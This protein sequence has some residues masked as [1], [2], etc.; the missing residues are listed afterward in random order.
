[1]AGND[2]SAALARTLAALRAERGWSLDQ[3]AA[4]SGVSK[5][6]LVS[7]EQA[8]S[9]PNL[10]TLARVG[11]AF[12]LPVTRLL[13]VPPEPGVR[14]TGRQDARTLVSTHPSIQPNESS[15]T[16]KTSLLRTPPP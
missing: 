7:L 4:R 15:Q 13:D 3:L 6:V 9:N 2:L 5:G 8:R 1:M 14:I 10:A 12:G 11:D 16:P